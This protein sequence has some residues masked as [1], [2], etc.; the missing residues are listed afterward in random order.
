MYVMKFSF[1]SSAVVSVYLLAPTFLVAQTPLKLNGGLEAEVLSLGRSADHQFVTISMRISNTGKN[2]AHLLLVGKE[3]AT[4]NKGG[5]Y[6][7][8]YSISGLAECGSNNSQPMVC[9][10]IPRVTN[11]TVPSQ[12]YTQIDPD[13]NIVVNFRLRGDSGA[14]SDGSTISFS[15]NVA[16]RVSDPVKDDAMSEADKQKQV[17]MMTLSFPPRVVTDVK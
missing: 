13:K 10:G 7:W 15:A 11:D 16:Y 8:R 1:K 4:D 5:V 2:T 3:A 17:R 14:A 12:G 6:N 9:A